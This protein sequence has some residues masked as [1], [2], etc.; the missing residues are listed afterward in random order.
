MVVVPELVNKYFFISSVI[1]ITFEIYLVFHFYS[2]TINQQAKALKLMASIDPLT[3]LNNRLH[4]DNIS[5]VIF[6]NAKRSGSTFSVLLIDIDWFKKV[7]DTYG[8]IVGDMSLV[9]VANSLKEQLR[10]GDCIARYGGEEFIIL[11]PNSNKND[12]ELVASKLNKEIADLVINVKKLSFNCTISIGVAE[13][14][15]RHNSL[16]DVIE[17]ADQALYQAK[18]TGRNKVAVYSS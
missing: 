13:F 3:K 1:V 6:E 16:L 5:Q 17:N 10:S 11:L 14:T 9:A 12:A 7:N 15:S 2:Q 8:H 18:E 4:F